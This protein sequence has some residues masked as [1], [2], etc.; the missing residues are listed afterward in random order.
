MSEIGVRAKDSDQGLHALSE[1]VGPE[2]RD[3]GSAAVPEWTSRN[4]WR[5][6]TS[7]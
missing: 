6:T 1:L 7:R 2:G 4:A 5:S 3:L